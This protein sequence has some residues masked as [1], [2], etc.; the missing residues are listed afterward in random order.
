M[1]DNVTKLMNILESGITP[2]HAVDACVLQLK[3]AG[4]E[5][6]AYEKKWE[7]SP[8]KRYYVPHHG[9]ALFAFTV[10]AE[11]KKGQMVRMAAAHTD[12]PT[13]RLKPSPDFAT[14]G[15]AQL[16]IEVYGGPILNTWLDRP[17]GVAGRVSVKNPK[18]AF[19][20]KL[21]YF[22][23]QSAILTIPNLAIHMNRDVNRGV[24]LNPQSD[25]I[26]L[27]G[28]CD[29]KDAD[30]K[31]FMT[32]LAKQLSVKEEDILDFEL[33]VYCTEKPELIGVEKDLLSSPRIDN[34][35]SCEALV[36]ALMNTDR[37][38]GINLIQLADHEEVGSTSK[39]GAA[40]I[41]LHDMTRRILRSLGNSE[42]EID[43]SMYE[44]MLV[45]ADVAHAVHPNNVGKADPLV[46]PILG[47]G[48]CIK[49]AAAQSYA[50]DAET[51]AIFA[52]LC[53]QA[54]VPYQRF[55]NRADMRGGSTLGAIASALTPVKTLD[56]GIPILAMHSARELMAARDM[57]SLVN[58]MEAYFSL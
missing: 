40:S 35:S 52:G 31:F 10:G 14:K 16:N 22:D 29:G 25:L 49:Q 28:L 37:K 51:I 34:L 13:L 50:T 43:A 44:A 26:P 6:L 30:A 2:F 47:K 19:A 54:K 1:S 27:V 5:E 48:L 12:Y 21:M 41:L 7:L 20:P 33:N 8:G 24:E 55:V 57:D 15:Y 17:L 38:E 4:F 32:Y 23:S 46:Q 18:N 9:S 36:L 3:E 56:I 11:Y 58:A 42:D 53:E 39:Q 45:S